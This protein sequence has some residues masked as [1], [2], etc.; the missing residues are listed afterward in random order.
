MTTTERDAIVSPATGLLIY[1]TT[2]SQLNNFNGTVWQLIGG[3]GISSLNGLTGSSQTFVNGS[4]VTMASTGTTHTIGW[5]GL[6][7]VNKGGTGLSTFGGT[8]RL[9][10]TTT[11][12][13]LASI[14]TAN[15]GVLI[16]DAAGV[17]GISTTLPMAVQGNITTIANGTVTNA[18]MANMTANSFKGN[19]TVAAASPVDLTAT[20]ATA[21]LNSFTPAL[22]GLAPSSGGGTSNFLRADGTWALPPGGGGTGT[23]TSVSVASANGF[24]GTIT[25]ATTIPEITLTTDVTGMMIGDGT[26]ISAA[27]AGTDYSDGTALLGT[28][29]LKSTTSSGNLSIAVAGDFPILN[30]NT[31]GNASTVT[32]NANLSGPV[33]S[34]GNTTSISNNVIT[35]SNLSQIA[36]Q[37]FKGRAT[38]GTGIVEDMTV[39]QAKSL[40]G[41]TGTNSGDQT[42][43]LTG[44]VTGSG[45]G[46]F[47]TTISANSVTNAKLSQIA[48]QTFKGRTTAGTGNVEDL[49]VAQVKTLLNMSGTNSGDQT[50]TLTGDITG[51]GT[52]SFASTIAANAVT[53]GKIQNVTATNTVLGRIT[54]GTGI[55]EEISTTGT[56]N[57]VRSTSPALVTP[58][59]I[60]KSDVGLGSVDNTS[61]LNKPIST[62][63]QTALNLKINAT[64]KGVNNGVASLDAGGKVP[65]T[66]LPTGALIYKGTWNAS[67]NT[68]T[69]SDATGSNGWIYKIDAAGTQNLGSGVIVYAVGD[70]VIHNGSIWQKSPNTVSVTSV[71]GQSGVVILNSSH[72]AEQT[73]LYYTD[74][75]ARSALSITAPMAYNSATGNFSL[76]VSTTINNGYLSAADWNIFNA[77]QPAGNYMIG[78]NGDVTAS[79]PGTVSATIANNAVTFG[80]M[81]A[82]T[83]NK[84]LGS[85]LSGTAVSE[86]TIGTGL[87]FTG[88]TLNATSSGGT[89]TDITVV[90]AN[91]FSGTVANPT[92]SPDITLTTPVTGIIKGNGTAISAAIAAD[93]PVLNQNTTGNAATVTTNANLT[94]PVISTGN[95]TSIAANVITN[96]MLSQVASQTFRGRTTAATGNVE[97]LT[98]TQATA[99]L[100]SFTS[101]SKGLVPASG[102]GTSNF[103]RADGTFAA[104]PG[105]NY[106]TLVTLGTDVVNNNATANTLADVT[107]LSFAVTAGITYRFE[108]LIAYTSAATTTGSRWTINGPASPTLLNYTSTYTLTATTQTANFASAYSIPSG[109]NSTSLA[110]GNIAIIK[111]IIKPSANGTVVIRFASKI[112]S[113]AITA[114]AGSTLEWW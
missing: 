25:N 100:N 62:A 86:I 44:E 6:L 111:G 94:G 104:P 26:S 72:I 32:T 109:G 67:T 112:A 70:E 3:A 106:R 36:T 4:N 108:A 39:S 93:F 71:N 2:T 85:G 53:Y 18:I 10:Y 35:N 68:P 28:G 96:A 29:I 41:I 87:S 78:L 91:G 101:A 99:M 88:T 27:T 82:I 7:P 95:A 16:T 48:T 30:Q 97:D 1:N 17:P 46:S 69:L 5:T 83:A 47:A 79:G 8:N 90:N 37:T 9:L 54:A 76:P 58:T 19:N 64:D 110:S 56:G 84:L 60:V 98:A 107:G 113:S 105:G 14:T 11:T 22:K 38:A 13:N 34:V 43:A 52:S 50:I 49:S 40:L 73:N 92:T 15:N 42:I 75:R 89:V 31:T 57:V 20:Q 63:E 103:L 55:I 12:D 21:M 51:T 66:Q 80:K 74:T 45:T 33:T 61:D 24:A 81:Q 114:K 65:L 23:V 59:G 102:G 77:K